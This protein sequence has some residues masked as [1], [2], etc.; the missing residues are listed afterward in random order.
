MNRDSRILIIYSTF[1]DGH[2][3]AANAVKQQLVAQG[4]NQIHMIDLMAEAYPYWNSLSRFY[5]IKSSVWFPR[6]RKSVV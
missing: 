1:G 3:Q 5:Y 6:D 2:L 4:I